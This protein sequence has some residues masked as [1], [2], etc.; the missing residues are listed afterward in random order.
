MMLT[1][2]AQREGSVGRIREIRAEAMDVLQAE[3]GKIE[4]KNPYAAARRGAERR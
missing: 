1:P 4:Q 2:H 3:A